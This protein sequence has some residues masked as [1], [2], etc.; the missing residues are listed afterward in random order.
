MHTTPAE[1]RSGRHALWAPVADAG[2]DQTVNE[3]TVVMLNAGN[4]KDGLGTKK[5]TYQWTQISGVPVT[6]DGV[7][8]P[9]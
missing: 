8:R 7:A 4:S 1:H 5:L 9:T 2:P 6:L 3:N